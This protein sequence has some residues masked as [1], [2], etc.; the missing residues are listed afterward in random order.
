MSWEEGDAAV[1]ASIACAADGAPDY[2]ETKR[3][4]AAA[5]TDAKTAMKSA[6][7]GGEAADRERRRADDGTGATAARGEMIATDGAMRTMNGDHRAE[8]E[9]VAVAEG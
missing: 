9:C 1:R 5:V 8:A 3:M 2:D 4:R 7:V 6:V